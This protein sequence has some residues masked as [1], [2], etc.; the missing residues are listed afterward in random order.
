MRVKVSETG[1]YT[2]PDLVAACG[3][4]RFEDQAVDTL[5]NPVLIIEV[6]SDST[7]RDDRGAKFT[8]YRSVVSLREYLLVSQHESRVEHYVRQP[9]NHWLL[10]EY[11]EMQDRI[12]LNSLD[13][14]LSLAEV[15]ERIF[16]SPKP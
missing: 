8:H 1:M 14:Y 10:T 15:N 9:G 11:Q 16:P 13:S 12:D 5:L 6:L 4:P 2:Y 3:E 7:E